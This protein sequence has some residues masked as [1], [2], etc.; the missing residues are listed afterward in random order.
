MNEKTVAVPEKWL[1]RLIEIA[2]EVP[3]AAETEFTQ[4]A[5]LNGFI[6]SANYLINN[7]KK[8]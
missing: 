3:I 6:S 4:V 2:T 5:Y 8:K 1:M 7:S